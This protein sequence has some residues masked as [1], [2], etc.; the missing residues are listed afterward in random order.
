MP[1]TRIPDAT[2]AQRLKV[3]GGRTPR[4]ATTMAARTTIPSVCD[5]VTLSPSATAWTGVPRVP[6]R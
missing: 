2:G 3:S 4:S 6:T 1:R 5:T